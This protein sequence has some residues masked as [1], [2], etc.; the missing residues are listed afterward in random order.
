MSGVTSA[1]L[2]LQKVT[3]AGSGDDTPLRRASSEN[4][5]P[6]CPLCGWIVLFLVV[7]MPCC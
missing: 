5:K 2:E 7:I 6:G 4:W 3:D 1:V